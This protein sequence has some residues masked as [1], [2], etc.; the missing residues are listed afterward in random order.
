MR[1]KPKKRRGGRPKAKLGLPDL[2]QSKAAVIGSLRSPESQRGYTH[3]IDEFIEWYCS[4]P[5]LSFNRTVVLRYRINLES[6]SLAPGTINVRLAAV[7]RLAYEAADAGLL[8]PELA[9]GIRRVKG[10]KKLGVRL[11]N[12]LSAQEAR[13]LWESPDAKT[14][15]G[16]RDRAIIAIPARLRSSTA[17]TGRPQ[18]RPSPASRGT[19]G[20]CRPCGKRWPRS[21]SSRSGL[22][23]AV[24]GRMVHSGSNHYGQIVSL[25]V[26]LGNRVGRR[27][28]GEGSLACRQT[29]CQ[30]IADT[31]T[32]SP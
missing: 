2:D 18:F 23:E 28:D 1:R 17:R 15:K 13:A 16:K 32:R 9:A 4:E 5:R 26:P 24:P 12:W 29:A 30:E 10:V 11:G 22:G 14:L 8:S 3:A 21:D 19:L 7:R 20:H 27:N 6:R 25:R 31:E